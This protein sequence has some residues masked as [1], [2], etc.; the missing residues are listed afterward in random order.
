[1]LKKLLCTACIG[2]AL[3]GLSCA[4]ALGT[5]ILEIP[6]TSSTLSYRVD[7][8]G[9]VFGP[10]DYFIADGTVYLLDSAQNRILSYRNNE[11]VNTISIA[12]FLAID[13]AGDSDDLY[14]IDSFLN[15]YRYDGSAFTKVSSFT[16]KFDEQLSNFQI[17]NGFGYFY[18]PE[19]DHGTTYQFKLPEQYTSELSFTQTFDGYRLDDDTFYYKDSSDSEELFSSTCELVVYHPS[20]GQT[21][22]IPVSSDYYLGQVQ[23]LGETTDGHPMICVEEV[24]QDETYKIKTMQSIRV[25]NDTGD[26]LS[27]YGVPKQTLYAT[28]AFASFD[29]HVYELS[30]LTDTVQVHL[31]SDHTARSAAP[32]LSIADLARLLLQLHGLPV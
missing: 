16:P 22:R 30:N 28:S 18:M 20:N 25:L 29:G 8:Q 17:S 32:A 15:L 13:L 12:D 9:S 3:T 1:M 6:V 19:G 2:A 7:E 10:Q 14:V 21:Q 23:Y 31:L 5:T 27:V 4:V 24:T 26:T 11:L